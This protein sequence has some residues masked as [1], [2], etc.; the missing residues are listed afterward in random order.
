LITLKSAGTGSNRFLSIHPVRN[1]FGQ[2]TIT[3]TVFDG[4]LTDSTT[5]DLFV[6]AVNDPPGFANVPDNQ[7]TD[8]DT[9]LSNIELFVFD[10]DSEFSITASSTNPLLLPAGSVVISG[11]SYPVSSPSHL[12]RTFLETLISR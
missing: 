3:L 12:R 8:E 5:F 9:S 6:N 10:I 1:R 7:T 11:T 4:A 2:A